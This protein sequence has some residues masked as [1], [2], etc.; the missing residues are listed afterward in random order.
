MSDE[1]SSIDAA[2]SDVLQAYETICQCGDGE[3]I[4][5]VCNRIAGRLQPIL[6]RSGQ[7][8]NSG[9]NGTLEGSLDSLKADHMSLS[10]Y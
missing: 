1:L 4:Q 5:A 8:Y 6:M 9:M 2:L 10:S 3:S 7:G